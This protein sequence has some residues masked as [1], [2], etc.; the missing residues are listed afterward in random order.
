M[1][2]QFLR[3]I[4]PHMLLYR[5]DR[6]GIAWIEDGNTGCEISVHP[7]IAASGSVRGMKQLGYW[8]KADRTVRSHGFIYNMDHVAFS[9]D[10]K[11]K[12][13]VYETIVANECRCQGCLER[14]LKIAN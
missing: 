1:A 12:N 4:A 10:D 11:D 2:K 13:H 7:N 3:E 8:D 14:K 9:W 5:D 6:T